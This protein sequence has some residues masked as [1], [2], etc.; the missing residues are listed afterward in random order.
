M[1]HLVSQSV[2]SQW[3]RK[4][5]RLRSSDFM[6]VSAA[7]RGLFSHHANAVAPVRGSAPALTVPLCTSTMMPAL[8]FIDQGFFIS[9]LWPRLAS[10]S[11]TLAG[12]RFSNERSPGYMVCGNGDAGKLRVVER[13]AAIACWMFM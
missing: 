9:T 7:S 11:F 1:A 2:G 8:E 4:R 13:G 3:C 5:F 12:M 10:S 6:G